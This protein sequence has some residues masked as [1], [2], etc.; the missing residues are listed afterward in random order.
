[1]SGSTRTKGTEGTVLAVA[2]CVAWAGTFIAQRYALEDLPP[3]WMAALRLVVA[4]AVLLPFIGGLLHFGRRELWLLLVLALLNQVGFVG[5]QIAGLDTIGAGPTAAIIYV[6]ARARRPA[7]RARA[8]RGADR[9]APDGR[10]ARL[11]R[12][13]DRQLPPGAPR[14]T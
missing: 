11:R 5:L 13:R 9:E 4:T 10:G 2:L 12:R 8:G 3:A 7:G 6:A 14:R 1:M